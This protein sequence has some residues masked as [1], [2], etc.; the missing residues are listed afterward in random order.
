MYRAA[1]PCKTTDMTV[2]NLDR[3]RLRP[4][5]VTSQKLVCIAPGAVSF[6]GSPQVAP[7][8]TDNFVHPLPANS[9]THTQL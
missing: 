2:V 8:R 5:R 4:A 3:A 1:W 6:A 9:S 7:K